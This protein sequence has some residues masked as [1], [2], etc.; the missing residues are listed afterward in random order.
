LETTIAELIS[1][2]ESGRITRRDLIQ[3]LSLIV[4]ASASPQAAAAQTPARALKANSFNHLSFVVS[5]YARTRDFYAD[6]LGLRVARDD[7]KAKQC[8]LHLTDDSYILPRNPVRR[9]VVPPVVN[10]FAVSIADWDKP[11]VGAELKRRGL[12][13]TDDLDMPADSFHVRDPD[14]YDLQLVN[15][16]HRA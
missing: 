1:R 2:F 10:H 12:H 14:G 8:Q 13:F 3:R 7:P 9:G 6:L 16:K 11:R 4:A 5:D 15:E